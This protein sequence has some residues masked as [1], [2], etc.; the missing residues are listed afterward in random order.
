MS[1]GVVTS[2]MAAKLMWL[3]GAVCVV[4]A[5]SPWSAIGRR[6]LGHAPLD[7]N[8]LTRKQRALAVLAFCFGLLGLY[9][10][11]K[12]ISLVTEWLSPY[13][14]PIQV[15]QLLHISAVAT[16]DIA[17]AAANSLRKKA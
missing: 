2:G 7:L 9:S 17:L 14:A 1:F 4:A 16:A 3:V 13:M 15:R 12:E 10:L 5:V 11:G 8:Q 6:F